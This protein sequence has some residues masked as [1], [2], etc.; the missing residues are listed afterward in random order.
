[1]DRE[2]LERHLEQ[3]EEHVALG[4]KHIARQREIVAE[5]EAGRQDT[6]EAHR[7]LVQ[8]EEMQVLHVED[9]NRLRQMLASGSNYGGKVS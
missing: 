6:A 1:M 4:E 7:L 9:R 8:F 2:L 3:A 5:L